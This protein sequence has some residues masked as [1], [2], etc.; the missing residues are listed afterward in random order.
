MFEGGDP[1]EWLNKADQYFELYQVHED[2]KVSIPSMHLSGKAAD[3]W[4]M[5]KH[6]FPHTWQGLA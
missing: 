2:K 6:E 5:F 4:Y 1:I 3:I